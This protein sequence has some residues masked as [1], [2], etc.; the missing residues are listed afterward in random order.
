LQI[1]L[2]IVQSLSPFL[3]G[4]AVLIVALWIA[5]LVRMIWQAMKVHK[6]NRAILAVLDSV[7]AANNEERIDGL[8]LDRV[9]LLRSAFQSSNNHAKDWWNAIEGSLLPLSS[10]VSE[11][12]WFVSNAA[13][14]LFSSEELFEDYAD[15]SHQA[16]PGILTALGLLGTFSALLLGLADLRY[17]DKAVLGL[18]DLINALSGKFFTSV[19]ALGS[20]LIFVLAERFLFATRFETLYSKVC[21][22]FDRVFPRLTQERVLIDIRKEAL[23]QSVSLS[24]ISSDLVGQLTGAFQQTI[25]PSLSIDLAEQ[26]TKQ[27]LPAIQKMEGALERLESQK[28]DS[29]VGEFRSL[30]ATLETSITNALSD[31][32]SRFHEQ[33]TGSA[34]SEFAAVQETLSGTSQMLLQMN[35]QFE[36]TRSALSN[37]VDAA[38]T[39][40]DHQA[41]A[42]QDQADA[43]RQLMHGLIEE[44][45]KN[46]SSN[47][48]NIAGALTNVISDL[49]RKVEDVSET[50]IRTVSDAAQGSQSSADALIAKSGAWTE[51]T[52]QQLTNLLES[53]EA[54]SG[55]FKAAGQSL[56]DAKGLLADVLDRNAT[57]LKSMETAARQVEGYTT[58][59]TVVARNTDDTQRR[60]AEVVALSRQVVEELKQTSA[61]NQGILEQYNRSLNEAKTVFGTLDTQIETILTKI[62]TGMREY[63]QTV[64]SNFGVIVKHSNDY[65][66]QI[67][68]VLQSQIQELERQ[69]EELTSVFSKA[70]QSGAE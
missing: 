46:A 58:A 49:S 35:A 2:H 25:L 28:Q 5:F 66:P 61:G 38:N 64:E 19:L 57:A 22:R 60:Q 31:M 34:H 55:E 36:L 51:A 37:L 3:R 10:P 40:S 24:N 52:S 27:L 63:V 20:S 11:D 26:L 50:M 62:N 4:F 6:A 12:R 21:G 70:L 54:R 43:L 39:S 47:L 7:P 65:L 41:K 33:L 23:C 14:D 16:V 17:T 48:Q 42:S 53:I 56:L 44:M 69:L 45:G 18:S 68:R 1:F 67:S 15:V 59:L 32:G 30:V 13:R 29:V 8:P 9:N